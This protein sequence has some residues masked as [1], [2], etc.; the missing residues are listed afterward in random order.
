MD[1]IKVHGGTKQKI[2]HLFDRL[3]EFVSG[4]VSSRLAKIFS[5]YGP[6]TDQLY[7]TIQSI[8]TLKVNL[9]S[10]L[11]FNIQPGEALVE[12]GEKIKISTTHTETTSDNGDVYYS[13]K[14]QY[15]ELGSVPV[16]TMTSF[17]Y[18]KTGTEPYST[19]NS[20]F[21]D[22]YT[23]V[24]TDVGSSGAISVSTNEVALGIIKVN[25]GGTALETG[26]SR[27][28]TASV[29]GVI[30]LRASYSLK[31]DPNVLDDQIILFRDRASTG[32]NAFSQNIEF[33]GT[34]EISGPINFT[35]TDN[36]S[37][38]GTTSTTFKI[39]VG[40]LGGGDGV[41]VLTE[42]DASPLPP[43]NFRISDNNPY[44]KDHNV[45]LSELE[46]KWNWVGLIGTSGTDTLLIHDVVTGEDGLDVAEDEL[47]GYDLYCPNFVTADNKYTIISNTATTGG[48]ATTLEITG[49]SAGEDPD[50]I[51]PA[52]VRTNG[53]GFTFKSVPFEDSA[54]QLD[55][56]RFSVLDYTYNSTQK[57]T[58]DLPLE[59]TWELS[60]QTVLGTNYSAF[61]VM[62]AG[63][64]DPDGA[65]AQVE[66]D[67]QSPYYNVLPDIDATG[68]AITVGATE[69]GWDA[70]VT[71]W[72]VGA[73]ASNHAHKFEF[74]WTTAAALDWN[75]QD[76]TGTLQQLQRIIN[77]SSNRSRSYIIG[78][79]PIQNQQVV[80]TAITDLVPSSGG[81]GIKPTD[82]SLIIP[83]VKKTFK[84]TGDLIASTTTGRITDWYDFGG[85]DDI[86]SPSN[87]SLANDDIN[88]L[89]LVGAVNNSPYPFYLEDS[90]GSEFLI[91]SAYE[92]GSKVILHL[93]AGSSP[94]LATV[95]TINT[96][97]IGRMVYVDNVLPLS[98]Q[99][100]EAEFVAATIEGTAV[101]D[102]GKIRVFQNTSEGKDDFYDILSVN[103]ISTYSFP[104]DFSVITNHGNLSL[105]VDVWDPAVS[106]PNNDCTINGT[107]TIWYRQ[108]TQDFGEII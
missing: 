71:G 15:S 79:R 4:N 27:D 83:V 76:S 69:F 17:V 49:I 61:V 55:K 94:Q 2:E 53:S 103:T 93:V 57:Y 56:A 72:E 63:S 74:G 1:R 25:V 33:S 95:A 78:V 37:I 100:V 52:E 26:W 99:G 108:F 73:D 24:L 101:G 42:A 60:L 5:S 8:T 21:T 31:I 67:Y 34:T 39:G 18:D 35:D 14:L 92:A 70:R 41:D 44:D 104:L 96:G 22:N 81:G 97:P 9:T 68:A 51:D 88:N 59:S 105:G 19:R 40:T 84:S 7:G 87:G 10:G 85:N 91:S 107:L 66:T 32:S 13:V 28:G 45:K 54:L 6:V 46:L 29:D 30:D 48:G 102:T 20:E 62:E 77:F 38:A 90:N 106:S 36:L 64:Y 89:A 98:I 3:Q 58:V 75:D 12:V 80:G 43:L 65:G 50:G 16:P 86:F 82:T 23:V 47:A 11:S